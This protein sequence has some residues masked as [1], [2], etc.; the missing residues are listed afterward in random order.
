VSQRS[1]DMSKSSAAGDEEMLSCARPDGSRLALRSRTVR[2][3]LKRTCE[4][5]GLPPSHFSTDFSR[6]GAVTRIRGLGASGDDRRDRGNNVPGSQVMN[7]THVYAD[8]LG[9]SLTSS[10]LGGYRSTLRSRR[11]RTNPR[12][13]SVSEVEPNPRSSY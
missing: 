13:P 1:L 11:R 5:D 3:E 10:L 7:S 2:E 8:G 6:R 12:G 9:P 4:V